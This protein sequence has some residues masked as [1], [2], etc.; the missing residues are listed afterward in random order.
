MTNNEL[1]EAVRTYVRSFVMDRVTPD[2]MFQKLVA[3]FDDPEL[4]TFLAPE[5]RGILERGGL[6]ASQCKWLDMAV[7]AIVAAIEGKEY[8][9]PRSAPP[10]RA[11]AAQ[12]APSPAAPHGAARMV[13]IRKDDWLPALAAYI[14]TN[15]APTVELWVRGS[16]AATGQLLPDG[17]INIDGQV[18]TP[19]R[20]LTHFGGTGSGNDAWRLAA[21]G[22]RLSEWYRELATHGT[23]H[24][25]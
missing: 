3:K 17:T 12:A 2:P 24:A 5:A 9:P 11:V 16:R 7:A 23:G 14:Q 19:T 4:W 21:S 6:T 22:K 8:E 10:P 25:E 18:A 13:T 1:V 20:W 15:G